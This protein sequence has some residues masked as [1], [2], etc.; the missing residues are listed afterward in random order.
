[1]LATLL[2]KG[3]NMSVLR[4]ISEIRL[5][6]CPA[7]SPTY[8]DS[9]Y[10]KGADADARKRAQEAFFNGL[11][12]KT[13]N[14][15]QVTRI[16]NN[17]VKV[18][19]PVAELREY[20]Y[21]AIVNQKYNET[22]GGSPSD[23]IYYCFIMNVEYVSNM[24]TLI[25]FEVDVIQTYITD[26]GVR[27]SFVERC[28]ADTDVIYSH[29][30]TEKFSVSNYTVDAQYTE[31]IGFYVIVGIA[32]GTVYS[33]D[34]G[35]TTQTAQ[36]HTYQLGGWKG[37]NTPQG[38]YSGVE[39]LCFDVSPYATNPRSTLYL[40]NLIN[41]LQTQGKIDAITD[42]YMIPKYGYSDVT[43][44]DKIKDVATSLSMNFDL[45]TVE[46]AVSG[47]PT[48][49]SGYTPKNKKLY[50]YP[51]CYL[52]VINNRGESLDLKWEEFSSLSGKKL[53]CMGN[54]YGSGQMFVMPKNYEG[55]LNNEPNKLYSLSLRNYP[56]CT[57]TKDSYKEWKAQKMGAETLGATFNAVGGAVAGIGALAIN[58][59][60][61]GLMLMSAG[62]S[63]VKNFGGI[64][65]DDLEASKKP[66]L[67]QNNNIE[68][69]SSLSQ[70]M[71]GFTAMRYS[72][73]APEAE[74][75]DNYF[76]MFGYAYNKKMNVR[77]Y[78]EN[79]LRPRFRY[80]KTSGFNVQGNFPAEYKLKFNEVFNNGITFWNTNATVG[81]YDNN[82][83][84]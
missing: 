19:Y 25:T 3:G 4:P 69:E 16:S 2:K 33:T 77:T 70:N 35:T 37:T 66:N 46:P 78:L 1:M 50:N 6:K 47:T 7:L 60:A 81:E 36:P 73:S 12:A 61:G 43:L 53:L 64:I 65:A 13:L 84:S 79:S 55:V 41:Y 29:R 72:L 71:F 75:I 27:E 44:D 82:E 52:K 14:E 67:V 51:F 57:Y 26:A 20:N 49:L 59:I 24:C 34:G 5:Y 76:T 17:Q 31:K 9:Y 83:L 74:E 22:T 10:F 32:S 45:T 23:R 39:Y 54:W 68:A 30:E 40:K 11:N 63:I 8:R 18:P 62:G 42:M 80:I 21:M 38:I 15:S 58:P 56:V 48:T 28:H